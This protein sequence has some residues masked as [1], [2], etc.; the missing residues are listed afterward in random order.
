MQEMSMKDEIYA[1]HL[2]EANKQKPVYAS[3]DIYTDKGVMLVRK[4]TVVDERVKFMLIKHK[5]RKSISLSV[6]V[7]GTVDAQDIHAEFLAFLKENPDNQL[8][9]TKLDL[10]QDLKRGCKLLMSFPL[11]RQKLTVME[12]NL[13]ELYKKSVAGAW[14]ALA[15]GKQFEFD[16]DVQKQTFLAALVRD[17]G[18]MHIEPELLEN[19]KKE[20]SVQ[21]MI[22][23]GHVIIGQMVLDKVVGLPAQVKRAF[24]EHHE[25]ADGAGYP[26]GKS[27]KEISDAGLVVAMSDTIQEILLRYKRQGR[28]IANL[29]GFLILNAKTYG[30]NVYKALTH[31]VRISEVKPNRLIDDAKVPALIDKLV[32]RNAQFMAVCRELEEVDSILDEKSKKKEEVI[33]KNIVA[34]I[35]DMRIKSGVPS[36]EYCNWMLH[37]KKH[38]MQHAYGEMEL[39]DTMFGELTWQID[40][41]RGF[42]SILMEAKGVNKNLIEKLITCKAL[43]DEVVE[44]K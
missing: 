4:G 14:Y 6:E 9:H 11:L 36:D 17:I 32:A 23:M 8:L 30:E 18:I 2:S 42:V 38:E 15:L 31:L 19:S 22:I 35:I 27:F 28:N 16:E 41:M 34:R 44:A 20:L 10:E 5:L 13:P 33:L 37:V 40:Q 7:E 29:E 25:R 3:E 26:K 21:R 1:D 39:V 12:L 24:F 43:L